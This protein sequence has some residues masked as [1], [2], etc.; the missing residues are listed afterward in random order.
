MTTLTHSQLPQSV[1]IQ[2]EKKVWLE[3]AQVA[4]K[5]IPPLWPLQNFVAVNPYLGFSNL[6]FLQANVLL[7]Q[8][9]HQAALM[10]VSHYQSKIQA[11]KIQDAHLD[12]ALRLIRLQ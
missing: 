9:A 2:S 1:A 4:C 12:E 11:G 5:R 7:E 10:P 6:H 8:S 3:K